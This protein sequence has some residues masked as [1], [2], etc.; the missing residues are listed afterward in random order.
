MA[1]S[2][3]IDVLALMFAIG[4]VGVIAH[5]LQAALKDKVTWNIF[6]YLFIDHKGASSTMMGAYIASMWGLYSL[7]AFDVIRLEYV[8]E[9]WGNGYIFK[10]FIH[11]VVET[12]TA[13]Y[14]CD[15]VANKPGVPKKER[16]A[17]YKTP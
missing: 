17:E 8:K 10:P 11:A 13:G 12:V 6:R 14:I 15:S 7:G 2:V 3:Q 9:A 16:R 1:D 4:F 5:W